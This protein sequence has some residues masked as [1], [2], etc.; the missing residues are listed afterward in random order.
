[1]SEQPPGIEANYPLARLTTIRTG[2][3]AELFSRV[4]AL[5]ELER[6]VA[7]AAEERIEVGV[8]GSGS[9]LLV[10]DAGV[11]GL[12]VKLDQELSKIDVDGTRI[13]CGGGARLP[14]VSAAAARA[15][16]CSARTLVGPLP[17]LPS[18]GLS[19]SGIRM[20]VT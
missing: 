15:A 11:R 4:G 17:N 7:W 1:M 2:G 13:D 10:A 5:G 9:N 12:V 14:A 6:I 18:P 19:S 16:T 20:L 3:P 8:V